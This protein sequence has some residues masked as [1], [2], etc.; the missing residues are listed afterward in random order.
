[1]KRFAPDWVPG[2]MQKLGMTEE[3]PLESR[4]VA[5]AIEQAQTKVEGHNF[6][7]RKR[8]VD[9]DDVI[10]EHRKVIYGERERILNGVDTRENVLNMVLDEIEELVKANHGGYEG[11]ELLLTE[12]REILPPEDVP[13]PEEAEDLKEELGDELMAA[14]EERYEQM[15]QL[16]GE[17]NMRKVE[18]WLLL[19][20]IDF[21]WRE[22]LTAID[23]MRNSIGLQ[24]YAQIDPLVAFKREGYD[25]YQQLQANIRKQ[26]AKTVF[27]VRVTD[28]QQATSAPVQQTAPQPVAAGTPAYTNGSTSNSTAIE[29]TVTVASTP[30]KAA[31]VLGRSN[32]PVATQLRTN[33]DDGDSS[34]RRVAVTAPGPK[35]G[36]NDPCHCGSGKKFKKCHGALG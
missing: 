25:M 10:N 6:D 23:D 8:L 21:H 2:M 31:P 34:S 17:E 18:H 35:V 16:V 19:E 27:K 32:A 15:E 3:M 5:R 12:V 9:F 26:V 7:I 30:P 29:G 33:L 20:S 28:A 14:A 24:A 13:T 36:R 22:H 11:R 1:M 4:M